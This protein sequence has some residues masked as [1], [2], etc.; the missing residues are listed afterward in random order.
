[1]L[2]T[3]AIFG[4]NLDSSYIGE[5]RGGSSDKE[6]YT[7]L[8]DPQ[9]G[10]RITRTYWSAYARTDLVSMENY[11]DVKYIFNDGGAGMQMFRFDGKNFDNL[12]FLRRSS[13]AF[14]FYFGDADNVLIIGAGGGKDVLIALMGGA[15]NITAVEINPDIMRIVRE[16]F[17]FN[18]GIYYHENIR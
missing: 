17:E 10:A 1:L 8:N 14:P 7:I 11:P 15:K 4:V 12:M 5:I 6:I 9:Y 18:G 16:E 3:S 2:L 13:T